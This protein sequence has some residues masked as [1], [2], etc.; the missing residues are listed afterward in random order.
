[1]MLDD[2]DRA[3]R[4]RR[5][6]FQHA[7]FWGKSGLVF[8]WLLILVLRLFSRAMWIGLMA[9]LSTVRWCVMIVVAD[10]SGR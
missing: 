1:M 6:W 10:S 9:E 7:F 2:V 4:S 8:S 5:W 3:F